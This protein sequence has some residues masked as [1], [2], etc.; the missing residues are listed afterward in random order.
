MV[1]FVTR[2]K[3]EGEQSANFRLQWCDDN[4]ICKTSSTMSGS[5][6]ASDYKST[7]QDLLDSKVTYSGSF[8]TKFSAHGDRTT[9][10]PAHEG[11]HYYWWKSGWKI[12]NN[13]NINF[14]EIFTNFACSTHNAS[15]KIFLTG[16]HTWTC[17][18]SRY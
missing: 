10:Y 15:H 6:S 9:D 13:Q 16:T 7:V 1:Y 8:N 12:M 17:D 4:N 18:W 3:V 2:K 14:Q 5:S 11:K